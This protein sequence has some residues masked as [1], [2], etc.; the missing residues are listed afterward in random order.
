MS[1]GEVLSM[2]SFFVVVFVCV[3]VLYFNITTTISRRKSRLDAKSLLRKLAIHSFADSEA[4][5]SN[6]CDY[7]TV[8]RNKYIVDKYRWFATRKNYIFEKDRLHCH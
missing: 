2:I 8:S 3:F 7:I 1:F 6:G 4:I 5:S